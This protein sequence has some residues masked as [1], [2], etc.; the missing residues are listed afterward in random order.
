LSK[1]LYNDIAGSMSCN[2]L[3]AGVV[4]GDAS[5]RYFFGL[6]S[7]C[8]DSDGEVRCAETISNAQAE[9]AD[10][11]GAG[12]FYR[13]ATDCS[14]GV[15]VVVAVAE[16]IFNFQSS[17]GVLSSLRWEA[18]KWRRWVPAPWGAVSNRSLR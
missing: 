4:F 14:P 5:H 17:P 3:C 8:C 2:D 15:R 7:L 11:E 10:G 16:A 18:K 12:R 13:G 1:R 9:T 6:S